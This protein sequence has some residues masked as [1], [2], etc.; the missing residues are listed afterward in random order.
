MS[1]EDWDFGYYGKGLDGYVHFRQGIK[2]IESHAPYSKCRHGRDDSLDDLDDLD[3]YD[4]PEDDLFYEPPQK[5]PVSSAKPVMPSESTTKEADSNPQTVQTSS[6]EAAAAAG[7]ADK[8]KYM[9][10]EMVEK[11]VGLWVCRECSGQLV[12][13]HSGGDLSDG[14][15]GNGRHSNGSGIPCIPGDRGRAACDVDTE[16]SASSGLLI[17]CKKAPASLFGSRRFACLCRYQTS[18]VSFALSRA[19]N[20]RLMIIATMAARVMPDSDTSPSDRV[21]PDRPVTKMTDVRI[22]LRFLL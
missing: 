18:L 2:E 16:S 17:P 6:P 20:T 7:N 13:S 14:G 12:L 15:R 4:D 9:G 19:W 21:T 3:E 1:M 5:T 10:L 8:E 11:Q 22:M